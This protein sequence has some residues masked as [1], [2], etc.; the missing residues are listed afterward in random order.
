MSFPLGILASA[1]H[2]SAATGDGYFTTAL[3]MG[4]VLLMDGATDVVSGQAFTNSACAQVADDP[5]GHKAYLA[6]SGGS[7]SRAV[8]EAGVTGLT[9]FGAT[10]LVDGHESNVSRLIDDGSSFIGRASART[11]GG[12]E[13]HVFS[14]DPGIWHW[15]A[16]V[17]D[18]TLQ[19]EKS[20]VYRDGIELTAPITRNDAASNP[21]TTRTYTFGGIYLA[22]LSIGHFS[23]CGVIH[24]VLT[25]AQ[26]AELYAAY[27][28]G[29]S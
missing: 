14:A 16:F 25:A 20:L 24:D 26:V 11:R 21:V 28:E 1:H 8:S 7:L 15:F 10:S 3:A 12:A 19:A 17:I 29:P 9:M 18:F 23:A 27:Q 6:A 2:A 4:A 13:R 22:L 5:Y